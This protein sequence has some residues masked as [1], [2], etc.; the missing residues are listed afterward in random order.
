MAVEQDCVVLVRRSD[1]KDLEVANF[2]PEFKKKK[3]PSA[4]ANIFIDSKIFEWTNYFLAG[5]K[6]FPC[7]LLPFHCIECWMEQRVYNW[8]LIPS[9][10]FWKLLHPLFREVFK[11]SFMVPFQW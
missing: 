11:H 7:N 10:D 1:G 2:L 3:F 5:F 8:R 6:V 4:D 9:R